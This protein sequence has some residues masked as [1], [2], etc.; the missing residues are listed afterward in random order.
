MF[1]VSLTSYF[2]VYYKLCEYEINFVK[3]FY[4]NKNVKNVKNKN[5]NNI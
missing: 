3:K 4:H 5:S 1:I 2:Y